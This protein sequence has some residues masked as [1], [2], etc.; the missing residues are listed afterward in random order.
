M[1]KKLKYIDKKSWLEVV[2]PLF[3]G[4]RSWIPTN[5][6]RGTRPTVDKCPIYGAPK[7]KFKAV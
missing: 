5:D 7:V 6:L 2:S 3:L 1:P 4:S